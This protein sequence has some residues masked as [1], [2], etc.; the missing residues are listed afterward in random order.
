MDD[1]FYVSLIWILIGAIYVYYSDRRAYR[2]GMMDAIVQHNR[3]TLTYSSYEDED[4]E[5]MIEIKVEEDAD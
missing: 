3:G 2:E 1:L 5:L 4:G